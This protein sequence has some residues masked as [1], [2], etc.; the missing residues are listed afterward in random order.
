[1]TDVE[2]LVRELYDVAFAL[3]MQLPPF[4]A[5]PQETR[6]WFEQRARRMVEDGW[7]LITPT[8]ED[9]NVT[10]G[11]TRRVVRSAHGT[12]NLDRKAVARAVRDVKEANERTKE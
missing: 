4:E 5:L 1:M 6:V 10:E 2:V 12:G 7:T 8:G 9:K 11:T 3:N